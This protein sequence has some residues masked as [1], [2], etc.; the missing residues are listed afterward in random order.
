MITLAL[1]F[2][3]FILLVGIKTTYKEI[4]IKEAKS[5]YP[6]VDVVISY[7]EY[8][9]SRLINRRLFL[10]TYDDVE[11]ALSFFNL[12]V[13]TKQNEDNHYLSLFSAEPHEFETFVKKDIDVNDDEAVITKS[14][15]EKYQ[16]TIGDQIKFSIL[17]KEFN[18]TIVKIIEDYGTFTNE[19]IF[20][21]KSQ[22]FSELYGFGSLMNLGNVVYVKT[23]DVDALYDQL[24]LD[25]NYNDYSVELVIDDHTIDLLVQEFTA[26]IIVAGVI[27]LMSLI[28]VLDSL[29]PIALKDI[30]QE[31][32][33]IGYLGDKKCFY[34]RILIHQWTYYIISSLI[35]GMILAQSV[36][37]LAT[38]IYGIDEIIW[39][40]T[41]SIL[42][43]LVVISLYVVIR[44]LGI[45]KIKKVQ[46]KA[47][48]FIKKYQMIALGVILLVFIIIKPLSVEV[49]ALI[50]VL[51]SLYMSVYLIAL[52]LKYITGKRHKKNTL[53]GLIH[54]KALYKNKYIH[55]TLRVLLISLIVVTTLITVRA[56]IANEI[57]ELQEDF[58]LD[59]MIVNLYNYDD[60]IL[61][62]V[63][64]Q[65]I[66]QADSAIIYQD[67]SL[68]V[69]DK[70]TISRF[71]VSVDINQY[72]QYF[73]YE[74]G[75]VEDIYKT[76]QYPY[77]LLPQS[78]E[79]VY[80]VSKGELIEIDLSK[81]HQNQTFIVAG[82][83]N[84]NYDHFIYSNIQDKTND[85]GIKTNA[86]FI[87][88]NQI[89]ETINTLIEM[90]SSS[91][92]YVVDAKDLLNTNLDIAKNVLSLFTVLTIFI[93]FSFFYVVYNQTILKFEVQKNDY[94]K[95]MV[96]G[97]DKKQ[98]TYNHF[99]EW[100]LLSILIGIIGGIEVSILSFYLR[101]TLLFFD[102]YKDIRTNFLIF[103]LAYIAISFILFMSYRI[104]EHLLKKLK[105]A[106]E[107]KVI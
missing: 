55:D 84:S 2:S 74:L 25:E 35:I 86:I 53:F 8:S 14:Y 5:L 105:L 99:K 77:V 78:Y 57:D 36:I 40:Q 70:E 29:F 3:M 38:K 95:I 61:N 107:F 17:N 43:S 96:L 12:Q 6:D 50:I 76:H 11:Y 64:N 106:N 90:Y 18:Y 104:I 103:L 58:Y 48:Q 91:M 49:N 44:H 37:Y 1:I 26:L 65:T 102:Y 32:K 81:T 22:L 23:A 28:I 51:I 72:D 9:A 56:F 68:K 85:L 75:E 27:V 34:K 10:E 13:M 42:I 60:T 88:S 16:L 89:D 71:F 67:V 101:D 7:D 100:I 87:T 39:I 94:A 19:S 92:Y 79:K 24:L 97:V 15:A 83:I 63:R 33:I 66:K 30:M 45:L 93:V 62:D 41:Y 20:V 52:C 21:D 98:L 80:D 47:L 4:F 69:K 73:G 82:F 59:L 31:K 54:A 46:I